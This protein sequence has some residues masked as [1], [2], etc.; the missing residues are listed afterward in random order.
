MNR[1]ISTAGGR[2]QEQWEPCHIWSICT[3]YHLLYNSNSKS[4]SVYSMPIVDTAYHGYDERTMG[5]MDLPWVRWMY[6][7]YDGRTMGMLDLPWVQWTYHGYNGLT[8]GTIVSL[9]GGS[10]QLLMSAFNEPK[11]T[12]TKTTRMLIVVS[13]LFRKVDFF[14]PMDTITKTH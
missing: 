13:M 3:C 5:T 6:H 14:A 1:S 11:M 7:G 8:M 12:N 4:H 2:S 10:I 9:W